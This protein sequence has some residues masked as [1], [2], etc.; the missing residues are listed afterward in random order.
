MKIPEATVIVPTRNRREDLRRCLAA[1]LP[2]LP[3]GWTILVCDD[4][5]GPDTRRMVETEFPTLRWMAGPRR[6]PGANRNAGA[7]ACS[8][9]WLVF[10]DDDCVPSRGLLPAYAA[11]MPTAAG[12]LAGP[13]LRSD[14]QK[15]SLLWEAPRSASPEELLPPSCNFA[16]PRRVFE[17]AG[18]FDERYRI[19]FEDMEFFA[20]LRHAGIPV[21]FVE[22][23]AVEHPSRPLPSPSALARRWE[24]RVLSSFDFGAPASHILLHLPRHV[25]LVIVSR[26]R[27]RRMGPDT[28]RAAAVFAA[29]YLV[30]L[31]RLPGWI[32]THRRGRRSPFW[33]AESASGRT[34]PRFGL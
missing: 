8:S 1:L 34:P 26:F 2:G 19:S 20:R 4:S 7:R 25:L 6:G 18:G 21:Q 30:F 29:E 22:A 12:V 33:V 15:D 9:A 11:A 16:L 14:D 27:G 31:C 23:A 17:E 32:R 5:D 3:E 24:A 10:L 28:L 13:T